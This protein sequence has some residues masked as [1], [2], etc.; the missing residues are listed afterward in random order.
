MAGRPPQRGSPLGACR[1]C[2]DL[3]LLGFLEG[4]EVVAALEVERLE[5]KCK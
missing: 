5:V 1:D 2:P 3:P 4:A